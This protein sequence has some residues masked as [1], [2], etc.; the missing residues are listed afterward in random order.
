MFNQLKNQFFQSFTLSF[1]WL[2]ILVGIFF[3]PAS[4]SLLFIWK[5]VLI[6]GLLAMVFGVL[7][8]YFWKYATTK[9]RTNVIIT[10]GINF[11]TGY[12]CVYLFSTS[13][14]EVILPYAWA[15]LTV[16]IIGHTF[17]FY[18]YSKYEAKNSSK[19]LNALLG[20]QPKS[21]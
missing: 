13:M 9:A 18:V 16:T 1:V 5:I 19:A 2:L 17:G 14:F 15:V 7:Y 8:E 20:E 10:S 21:N 11:I 4:V 3:K 6:A 12:L